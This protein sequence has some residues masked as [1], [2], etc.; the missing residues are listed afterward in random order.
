[1]PRQEGGQE[2]FFFLQL[3]FLPPSEI[4]FL[5]SPLGASPLFHLSMSAPEE[6]EE[7]AVAAW[8]A[9]DRRGGGA[10]PSRTACCPR[11]PF[12]S[13]SIPWLLKAGS[14]AAIPCAKKSQGK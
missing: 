9:R 5:L 3:L 10:S 8:L 13:H 7:K 12:T 11:L 14:C 2:R 6:E 4:S 1:M